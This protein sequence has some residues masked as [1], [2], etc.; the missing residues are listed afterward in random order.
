MFRKQVPSHPSH[1]LKRMSRK[2]SRNQ[3]DIQFI[4]YVARLDVQFIKQIPM[5]HR[6][7]IERMVEDREVKFIK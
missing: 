7:R 5:H 6:D 4:K 2:M 3:D 1:K